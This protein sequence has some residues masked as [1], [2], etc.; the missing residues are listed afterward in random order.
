MRLPAQAFLDFV[1]H[2][3]MIFSLWSVGIILCSY[4]LAS[5]LLILPELM[6]NGGSTTFF[7][8]RSFTGAISSGILLCMKFS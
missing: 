3:W 7:V 8:Y 5:I 1:C 6:S 2:M 4:F